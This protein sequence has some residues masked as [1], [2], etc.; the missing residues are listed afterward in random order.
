METGIEKAYFKWLSKKVKGSRSNK[1]I[2]SHLHS[3]T[4]VSIQPNDDNRVIDGEK[5]RLAFEEEE[6]INADSLIIQPCSL[7]EMIVALLERAISDIIG[8]E[9]ELS[10]LFWEVIDNVGYTE[11][12]N[13][14]WNSLSQNLINRRYTYYGEGGLFPLKNAKRDQREA[15]LW[16]QLAEY[17]DERF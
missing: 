15:E 8:E 2:L 6:D 16:Y 5:L 3:T 7:L 14:H 9:V 12:R 13:I 17:L 1:E 11:L 10:D 4:F